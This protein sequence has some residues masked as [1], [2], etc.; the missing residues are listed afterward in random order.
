[1]A[2]LTELALKHRA[3][4]RE[5]GRCRIPRKELVY[6]NEET[7]VQYIPRATFLHR[8]S[9]FSGCCE[10][11]YLCQ[12]KNNTVEI[13][14]KAFYVAVNNKQAIPRMI[15]LQNHTECECVRNEMRR[16]RSTNCQCPKHFTD[17]SL[18]ESQW[19][20]RI[21]TVQAQG[22]RCRCDCH[23]NNETCKRLKNGEEG[24]SVMERRRIL[25]GESSPPFCSYGAYD[26]KNG[27]CPRPGYQNANPGLQYHEFQSNGHNGKS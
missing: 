25:R 1:M 19:G 6:M 18:S 14:E 11:G 7:N 27:R 12:A 2:S 15:Q 10:S 21:N 5:E 8:C 3:E 9:M 26:M 16:K 20:D 22:Q 13:V 23:L 17:F 24:F 4:M